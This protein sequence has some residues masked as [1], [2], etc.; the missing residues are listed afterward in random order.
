MKKVITYG[1]YDLLHY[2]HIRLLERAK[3]LGDYLIVGVTADDFDKTRGKINVQQSLIERIESV[4]AT[5][6]ADEIIVEEYEGQKIDDIIRHE[7]DI[8]TVGSDW[9]GKFDYL[10]EYCEV[11]YLDRT[12]GISSSELRSD[13]RELKLGII[14]EKNLLTKIVRECK[15]VNGIDII[16]ICGE[17]IT[18]AD[19]H[20]NDDT[21][22]TDDFDSLLDRCDAVYIAS[23]PETHYVYA[24]KA[25]SLGK[26]VLCESPISLKKEEAQ[27][28]FALAEA[29]NCIFME[30][31]KTAYSTAYSRLCLLAK[32]GIIGQLVSIEATCTSLRE[33]DNLDE[34]SLKNTWNSMCSW[35]PTAMLP[36]FQLL[37]T[38]YSYKN[39]VSNLVNEK[40]MFDRFTKIDYIYPTAVAS[41]K[42]AK[43]IKSEGELI[44]SGTKGY[45]YV[46]APWWKTDYFEIRFEDSTNNKRYFYQLDGEGIRYQLVAFIKS[47]EKSK[48]Y[49]CI[50]KRISM[51]IANE[52]EDFYIQKLNKININ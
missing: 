14:G 51:Q 26:H 2:G 31:L 34:K 39:V 24:K 43:G 35:G 15:F 8:F 48:S 45:I 6:L 46:P 16:G 9:V 28:L 20:L 3:A 49:S 12:E 42:V 19:F 44:I 30:S 27:E 13:K 23:H 37:G 1:T 4:Y 52:L 10:N 21:F 50:S 33:I 47:V 40:L 25:L 41:I 17:E 7:I 18:L 22:I 38:E 36:I 5:G 11:V 32:T 29:E